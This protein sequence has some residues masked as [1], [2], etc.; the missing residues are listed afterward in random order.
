MKASEF[1]KQVADEVERTMAFES[2]PGG[3]GPSPEEAVGILS[4]AATPEPDRIA[5]LNILAAESFKAQEFAALRPD[6]MEALR[7]IVRGEQTPNELWR[8][9]LT[10]L[11][12]EG[13]ETAKDVLRNI[14]KSK[15]SARISQADALRLLAIDD[16]AGLSELAQEIFRTSDD[17]ET[18]SEALRAMATD[19][20]TK[21]LVASVFSD[22]SHD[23]ALRK[24]AGTALQRLDPNAFGAKAAQVIADPDEDDAVRAASISALS[25][26]AGILESSVKSD[27]KAATSGQAAPDDSAFA[28]ALERL[29]RRLDQETA[30]DGIALESVGGIGPDDGSLTVIKSFDD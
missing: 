18:R 30:G 10:R 21:D 15:E 11:A 4:N 25:N 2:V 8:E 16:H 12:L 27:V 7:N 5:A 29:D 9:A 24:A 14:L 13:D 17:I 22:T 6:F 26:I 19:P 20:S 23:A 1:R 3:S 28:S